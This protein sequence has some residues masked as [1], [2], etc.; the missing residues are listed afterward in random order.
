MG[1]CPQL[2]STHSEN[3]HYLSD[4][5]QG[6]LYV[7]RCTALLFILSCVICTC[8]LSCIL[9]DKGNAWLAA[10]L[11]TMLPHAVHDEEARHMGR[12]LPRADVFCS[13]NVVIPV[14][15]LRLA[16][17]RSEDSRCAAKRASSMQRKMG[18][19]E[20]RHADSARDDSATS[21][22]SSIWVTHR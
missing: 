22:T 20:L 15:Y 13:A 19:N 16:Q 2:L 1:V 11:C 9:A 12:H 10:C 6:Y 14:G 4:T 17:A 21:L 3:E 7:S 8:N 5:D 18:N